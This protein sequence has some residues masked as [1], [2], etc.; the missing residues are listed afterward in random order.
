MRPH[1]LIKGRECGRLEGGRFRGCG[2]GVA[3]ELFGGRHGGVHVLQRGTYRDEVDEEREPAL[4]GPLEEYVL[5]LVLL[6]ARIS[7]AR[8]SR[9]LA[10]R[11]NAITNLLRL[12]LPSMD[13]SSDA[14]ARTLNELHHPL[15]FRSLKDTRL[16]W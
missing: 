9:A 10:I 1:P 5:D 13:I 14:E 3:S 2:D 4:A 8:R 16:P 15:I 6:D 7:V 12:V 11:V